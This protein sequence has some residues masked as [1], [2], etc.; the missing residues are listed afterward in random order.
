MDGVT[1][2]A[3]TYIYGGVICHVGCFRWMKRMSRQTQ[4]FI[5]STACCIDICCYLTANSPDDHT[6]SSTKQNIYIVDINILH[7]GV[8]N[9]FW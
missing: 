3:Q 4:V 6:D 1:Q 2:S 5:N 8:I 9:R 7:V